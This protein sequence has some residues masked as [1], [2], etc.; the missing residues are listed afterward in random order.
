MK[1]DVEGMKRLIWSHSR[2]VQQLENLM[3]H[4]LPDLHSQQNRGFPTDTMKVFGKC[5]F[6]SK[7]VSRRIAEE[8]GMPN[9]DRHLD[10]TLTEGPV[11]LGKSSG[12]SVCHRVR[13]MSPNGHELDDLA[14]RDTV[15]ERSQGETSDVSSLKAEVAD[16]RKDV[17]YLRSTDFTL[18]MR[19]EDDEDAPETSGMP[20]ATTRDV[21]KGGIAY[22]ELNAETDEEL[23][24][25]H[26][27]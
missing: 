23:I 1:E 18:L 26:N 10:L 16:L 9:E 3:G 19:G 12:H 24:V 13:L 8:V 15:C 7:M 20:P 2:A 11:K 17:D 14:T 6:A 22:E 21:Q 25:A 5:I 27:E 4:A